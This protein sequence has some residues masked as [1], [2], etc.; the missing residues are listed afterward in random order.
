MIRA[1][2]GER[3]AP[4]SGNLSANLRDVF[5]SL[6]SSGKQARATSETGGKAF[7]KDDGTH[8]TIERNQ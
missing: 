4:V 5:C 8:A 3:F 1:N 6:Q 7:T 2:S